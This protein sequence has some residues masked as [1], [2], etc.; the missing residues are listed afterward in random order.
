MLKGM[1]RFATLLA[2]VVAQGIGAARAD[3]RE[4]VDAGKISWSGSPAVIYL[5]ADGTTADEATYSHLVLKYTQTGDAGALTIADGV[6]AGARIL[7]VGGGGAGGTS[8]SINGGAG[9][10]GGAGGTYWQTQ[11]M[12]ER[13]ARGGMGEGGWSNGGGSRSSGEDGWKDVHGGNGGYGGSVGANGGYGTVYKAA[14]ATVSGASSTKVSETHSAI[15]Y[16][17][18]FDDDSRL[19][20]NVMVKFGYA[21][22]AA[23]TTHRYGYTFKGWYTGEDGSGTKLYEAN[24]SPV[25]GRE[26]WTTARDLTLYPK[27]ER[28]S[29]D[30][31]AVTLWINGE[32]VVEGTN[33]SGDGWSYNARTGKI[34]LTRKDETYEIHGCDA[35]GFAQIVAEKNCTVK[36]SDRLE[37]APGTRFNY[38]PFSVKSSSSYSSAE[39]TLEVEEGAHC[40]LTGASGCPAIYVAP[41]DVF[42]GPDNTLVIKAKGALDVTGGDNAADIGLRAN[43]LPAACGKIYVETYDNW[44]ANIRLGHGVSD[45]NGLVNNKGRGARFY[46][47]ATGKMVYSV[48]MSFAGEGSGD[49]T[50][51]RQR[52]LGEVKDTVKPD[53]DGH[54][55][56]WMPSS[57]YEWAEKVNASFEDGDK[58]WSAVVSGEHTVAT[59]FTP[60]DIKVN[61]EDIAHHSGPGWYTKFE[62]GDTNKVSLVITNAGPHVVSGSGNVNFDLMCDMSLTVSN[63]N[64]D[65]E[66]RSGKCAMWLSD[67]VRLDL[68]LKGTNT[69][70]SASDAPGI[71]VY[72]GRTINIYGDDTSSLSAQGGRNSAGIGG[73]KYGAESGTINISGGRITAIGG[74]NAAG[75]GGGQTTARSG[76]VTISGGIVTARGGQYAAGIGGG[77]TGRADVTITGGTVFPTAGTKANAIGSGY[78]ATGSGNNTFGF[79]AI[80]AA[81]DAVSPAAKNGSGKAV[82]PVSF[83]IGLPYCNVTSVSIEDVAMTCKSLWT[84]ANGRLTLWLEPTNGNQHTI[85]ITAVD[86]DGD[87]TT[88]SWGY[89]IDD[90]GNTEFSTDMLTVDGVPV[91]GGRSVSATGWEYRADTRILAISS[92]DHAITGNSTN[93]SIN[94]VVTGSDISVTIENL[95]LKTPNDRQSPFVVSNRCTLTLVGSSTIECICNPNGSTAAA[96]GSKYTAAIEV[97]KGASL[98]IDGGGSLTARGGL[99][100]AGIG[101]RGSGFVAAGSITINGGYIYAEGRTLS[102]GG[103]AGIGGGNECGV[104]EI[105]INGGVVYAKGGKGAAG[106]G[107]GAGKGV[108]LTDGTFR[109]TGGTVLAEKGEG[110]N[111]S[112]FVTARGNTIEVTTGRLIVIDGACSVRPKHG[113]VD[114]TNPYP[115]PVDSNGAELTYAWID[116]LGAGATVTI[117]DTMWPQYNGVDVVADDGGAVC[118]W[119]ERTSNDVER[120]IMIQSS[121]IPGGSVSFTIN[122]RS[123][124]VN[125]ADISGDAD[126]KRVIDGKDCWRV[127]VTDLPA[128]ERLEVTGIDPPF[129]YGSTVSDMSGESNLY[130]PDGDHDFKVGDYTYHASVAGAPA[131]ATYEVG[132]RVNG[133]DIGM[134]SGTGWTYNGTEERLRLE[135]GKINYTLSGTNLERRVSV[136]AAA[137][138]VAVSFNRL[139]L[140]AADAGPFYLGNESSTLEFSGGTLSSGDISSRVVVF[141]GTYNNRLLN[142]FAQVGA[143][144]YT[145]AYRVTVGG[146]APN[147]MVEIEDIEGL[148]GYNTSGIYSDEFGAVHL[149]LP[150]GEYYFRVRCGGAE[151]EMVVVVDGGD[152]TAMEY[153]PTGVIVNGR[154][155]A[156]LVGP[157]WRNEDGLVRFYSSMNYVVSGT[158]DGEAVTLSV[159][160]SGAT[161]TLRDLVMT[162]DLMFAS[163]IAFAG[164]TVKNFNLVLTGTN[165]I[166]CS[167]SVNASAAVELGDR[168]NLTISGDGYMDAVGISAQAGIGLNRSGTG[169]QVALTILSG[170]IVA[171]GDGAAGIGG[172]GGQGGFTVNIYGGDVTATGGSCAAG[173]GGGYYQSGG[174]VT[175]TNGIVHATGGDGA[176]GIGGGKNGGGGHSGESYG[177]AGSYSQ[178]G[179]TVI[180][181]GTNGGADIG[182]GENGGSGT[183]TYTTITG[184]S[185]D[186]STANITVQAKDADRKNVYCVTIN[187]TRPNFDV[188][189]VMSDYNGYLL[190]GVKTD[191]DGKIYIWLPNGTYYMNIGGVPFRAIVN[192]ADTEAETWSTGVTVNGEDVAL[193]SGAGWTYDPTSYALSITG[194]DCVVSGTNTSGEVYLDCSRDIAVTVSNLVLTTSSASYAPIEI[195][196]NAT[197]SVALCGENTLTSPWSGTPAIKVPYSA[198]LTITNIDYLVSVPGLDD[199]KYYTNTVE[200]IEEVD[201]GHGGVVVVTNYVDIVTAVTNYDY[202]LTSPILSAYGGYEAAGIGGGFHESYGTIEIVGGDI[203]AT[204]GTGGAGIGS[205]ALSEDIAKT[206]VVDQGTVRISGGKVTATGG[207]Y[208]AGIGGGNRHTGGTIEISGGE[209]KAYGDQN[210]AGIGGGYFA[211]GYRVTISGGKVEAYGGEYGAGIGNGYSNLL[212]SRDPARVSISGGQVMAVGGEA[213]SGIGA[214]YWDPQCAAVNI[215]GG[216]VVA[217]GGSGTYGR[218][219]D[220]IGLGGYD[221]YEDQFF[222]LT[223]KGASVHAANRTASNEYA[224]PAPS[225]GT[226]RVWCVTVATEKTNELVNVEY[227]DGFSENSDIY[228]DQ[229]GKIYLWLPNGTYT[230]SAGYQMYTATVAGADT[231]AK[232]WFTGVT[233]DGVDVARRTA[234]GKRWGY[235]YATKTLHI[236]GDCV[237]S[238]TNTEGKVMIV[239]YPPHSED[240]GAIDDTNVSFTISNLLLRAKSSGKSPI[241]V[242]NGT[243]TVRLAGANTLDATSTDSYAGLNVLS[244]A[245]LIITNLEETALL[246]AYSGEDAAAIG[247]NQGK[248]TGEKV[249]SST[250]TIRINGG[251]IYAKA[252]D[253]GAGIGSGYNGSSGDIYISGGR[254]DAFGGSYSSMG[255]AWCGAGIGGGDSATGSGR[256]IVISGGTVIAMGGFGNSSKYAADIGTGYKGEYA[257]RVEISGG[258]VRPVSNNEDQNF[259]Q[260][261]SDHVYPMNGDGSRVYR[262]VLGGL[263]PNAKVEMEMPGYGVNDIYANLAG[264]VFVWLPNGVYYYSI[265]GQRY[266]MKMNNGTATVVSIP[267]SYGVEVDGV[268]VANLSGEG[269]RYEVFES[270]LDVTNACV[271]SGTNTEG[272]INISV[273]ATGE[274]ALTISNLHLKATSGSPITILHGT[275]TLCLAGTNTLDAADADGHPGLHVA[276]MLQWVVITNLHE[277]AKL[278][279]RGGANAAGIGADN[280]DYTGS[281][282]IAGGI[283]EAAGGAGGAGIGSGKIFGFYHIGVTG[284][285]VIPTA[286]TDSKAIGCSPSCTSYITE[287]NI[288]FTGGSIEATADMVSGYQFYYTRPK[289]AAGDYVCPVTIPGFTPNAKVEMEIDG[290][291]TYDIYA[292]GGGN[293]HVWLAEGDYIFIL[294]GVPHLAH[295]TSSGAAAEPWLSGVMVDGTDAAYVHDA[296]GK[297]HYRVSNKTLYVHSGSSLSDCV[298]ITGTNTESYV[299]IAATNDVYMKISEL[300]IASSNN[301]PIS[302]RQS[303]V[304]VAFEGMNTLDASL[305][306]RDG[307][308]GIQASHSTYSTALL[309]LTNLQD[310]A[311]I[312]AKGGAGASG[313]GG[314][315]A[316]STGVNCVY[317]DIYGG[318]IRATGSLNGAGIGGGSYGTATVNIYG[319]EIVAVGGNYATGIGSGRGAS[320][321]VNIMGGSVDAT[322]GLYGGA[323]IGSGNNQDAFVYIYGG[324]VKS[325]SR[326]GGAAI[327]AGSFGKGYV[328]VSGG[329]VVPTPGNKKSIGGDNGGEVRFT[330]GSIDAALDM[331]NPAATNGNGVAVFPVAV[332]NLTARAKVAFDGLPSY[333]GTTDIY[334]DEEGKVYLWLPEN[335]DEGGITP[336]LLAASPR[337][338]L[339]A[340]P[341]ASHTFSANGYS[342]TVSIPAGG[343]EAV[344]ERGDALELS[345][346]KITGFSVADGWIV[347]SVNASPATWMY[348]FGDRLRVYA[349]ETLPVPDTDDAVLELPGWELILEDGDN[350]TFAVPLGDLPESMFFKVK[351]KEN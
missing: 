10:G 108:T 7:L 60:L 101:S 213:A 54:V 275:N 124:T 292:D 44:F 177:D 87:E 182:A 310:S 8:V 229:D 26:I 197:A 251:M 260:S 222:P 118:L 78:D 104:K 1:T 215:T 339:G 317:V 170:E 245:T 153:T 297:W 321:R 320:G 68:T 226:E 172:S 75:I 273:D 239:A 188:G 162:N 163:P 123:N 206:D 16:T 21:I 157:G 237:V 71:A 315:A 65:V 37:M 112:D 225:N 11:G 249:D 48:R 99:A 66:S 79:A 67:G 15:E 192:G 293:I 312:V 288:T 93:G 221:P 244:P 243:V 349:S 145:N 88:K 6:K 119:G 97:P 61:G 230:F 150:D 301:A 338:L 36:I 46:S 236:I 199:I 285:T 84:D 298:T 254:I 300:Y 348:G 52:I 120:A 149:Y 29:E 290:Y 100:G 2:A 62:N 159:E 38:I 247:G 311:S 81:K 331:V 337:R 302:A 91:V 80:Y 228:A 152:A 83:D 284:G 329:T 175:I 271:I 56:L 325:F 13:S 289:N 333:Y 165:I 53:G 327:G 138:G 307:Y 235:D 3:V 308:A 205:G 142:A 132:I 96:K 129:C 193:Q 219:P 160:K 319:G 173:I 186:S 144:L 279:A 50:I 263:A 19:A 34:R 240:G 155:V 127:T 185:L 274:F 326:G 5:N 248:K 4:L 94:V 276:G 184:G 18:T 268:D 103:G 114:N 309:I 265:D 334:A 314:R 313:I 180:A 303:N 131:V 277:G 31:S 328:Y 167:K 335:W 252:K 111:F 204:G 164:G 231:T 51:Y 95:I 32:K 214:G 336:R 134:E 136:C 107:G 345:E 161:L 126:E 58:I 191:D 227:L 116:G 92:G 82:Y 24:G 147:S 70:T 74:S 224:K 169:N 347:I 45:K 178:S 346:L 255:T 264:N 296:S 22:P 283:V 35:D 139:S 266:A 234:K 233:A 201:D 39:A 330:G 203:R 342:Y 341:G 17:L 211:H 166:H 299:H 20:T 212:T 259:N 90:A 257:Y 220:D 281:I 171:T 72:S 102:S 28:N 256:S 125:Q 223:I 176:A 85:T 141:G 272:K 198:T 196:P 14:A 238:G 287:E 210:G 140:K 218:I 98:V 55:W 113:V 130:L 143:D 207:R 105:V 343:G 250:G 174:K 42:M 286:G 246:Q 76:A 294:G 115:I 232:E 89:K 208:A 190:T 323:G 117:M 146:L 110:E 168:V 242:T 200:N 69:L 305:A 253:S 133:V 121:Y 27:W 122:A 12:S 128:G 33:K 282:T 278:V 262:A 295:V 316:S 49:K 109:V 23:P 148:G 86:E 318:L 202:V 269:W 47:Q 261:A 77:H 43:D 181:R 154:D 194:A 59:A 291:N 30:L 324:L 137:A 187:T 64:L 216:T 350:A 332:S 280:S 267:D 340:T 151:K 306:N 179:G 73:G 217:T 344:A 189:A 158:N 258:S 304:T 41:S 9:G 195:A 106:I 57:D 241:S 63:L 351:M 322:S 135:R 270:R 25:A 183:S 156:R 209:V 40:S